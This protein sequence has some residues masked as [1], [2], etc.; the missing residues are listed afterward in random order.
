MVRGEASIVKCHYQGKAEDFVIFIDDVEAAEK[1]KT[2]K[3]IPL[4]HIVSSFK[5]FVTKQGKQG[6][7]DGASNQTLETEFGT[8]KDEEV[9]KLII[10]KGI[11]Q[12]TE[13]MVRQGNKN[14]SNSG[15]RIGH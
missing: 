4:A 9:I 11:M 14:E 8:S 1:W 5:V 15:A 3:S 7:L 2:D 6:T 13:G 12:E 10:E